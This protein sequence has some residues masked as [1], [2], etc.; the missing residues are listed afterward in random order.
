MSPFWEKTLQNFIY[1]HTT[2]FLNVQKNKKKKKGGGE[3]K[4]CHR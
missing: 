2:Y 1:K 3:F 4:G